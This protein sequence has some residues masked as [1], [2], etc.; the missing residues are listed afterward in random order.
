MSTFTNRDDDDDYDYDY[1]DFDDEDLLSLLSEQRRELMAAESLE[2]DLDFAFRLQLQEA[3]NA[4]IPLLPSTAASTSASIPLLPSTTASTSASASTSTASPLIGKVEITAPLSTLQYEEISKLEQKL[5]DRRQSEVETRRIR[6]D[7]DRRIHDQKVA[8]E[9]LEIPEEEW[10][11]WGDDFVKEEEEED[12]ESVVFKLYFKGLVSEEKGNKVFGGI[13]IAI[14][15]PMNNL[16]FEI[17]KPLIGNGRSKNAAEAKAL[18]EGLNA[19]LA[20]DLKRIAVYCHCCPLYNFV[21]GKWSARQRK[22]AVL[23]NQIALLRGK[24]VYCNPVLV[25]R[26]DI[27]YAFRFARE[28]IISQI[29]MQPAESTHERVAIIEACVI[30][31]EDTDVEHIFSVDECQHRY[32]FSCMKQHVEVKLLHGMMPKC[33]HEGCDS[34][35]NV[36]SCRK[37][38]TPKLIEM[39]CLRIKEASIP[40][41][42]KIYCP[43]PKCSALMSKTEVFEYAKSAVAAGLQCVGARKCSKCHG[44]FCINCKVPW[45]DNMTCSSYKRM[46]PNNPAEDVKL[47][48]LATRNL[49]RQCVKCNHM[50]ELAEGCYHMTCR[51]GYDF[52]Y[53]CGAEWKDKKATCSCPLWDEDNILYAENDI[54]FDEDDFDEDEDEDED[55]YYDSDSD[56][57][58]I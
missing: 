6:K 18:I 22:V 11:E 47:K 41:S 31:L 57:Y 2:T 39:M 46:N 35:L 56:G 27:E 25:P 36:E 29:T 7:L 21:T 23:I 40:V 4:S 16:V 55:D 37:F 58:V 32:C 33:P 20:L 42:E 14:C 53:N 50:I 54:D 49:W 48:S 12:T 15:D 30:C 5:K 38:L 13:G 43:Y 19:A 34:L 10:L 3:I 1:E 52:C 44:L 17:S 9:V 26:N 24:F 8:R 45:H 51:C 28:A